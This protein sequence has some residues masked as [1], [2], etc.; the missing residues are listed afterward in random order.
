MVA[1]PVLQAGGRGFDPHRSY[2]NLWGRSQIGK[3]LVLQTSHCEFEP[4]RLHRYFSGCGAAAAHLPWEQ[5]YAG[6]NP[7]ILTLFVRVAQL[8]SERWSTKPK[9]VGSSLTTD[10][11]S[12]WLA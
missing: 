6:S 3:A 9:A 2:Q 11:N 10:I 4:R 1:V 12:G 8:E 5:A 7:A